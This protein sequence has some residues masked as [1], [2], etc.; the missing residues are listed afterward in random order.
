MSTTIICKWA[1][2]LYNFIYIHM[3]YF[4]LILISS[5]PCYGMKTTTAELTS[6]S[7]KLT[8]YYFMLLAD[9][10]NPAFAQCVGCSQ[11]IPL[12]TFQFSYL[13]GRSTSHRASYPHP[14]SVT[15]NCALM[16]QCYYRN[17]WSPGNKILKSLVLGLINCNLL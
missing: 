13:T 15:C 14:P 4:L 16:L 8:S 3:Y 11:S 12:H 2:G 6:S 5:L 17:V 10:I 1:L 9:C 7:V